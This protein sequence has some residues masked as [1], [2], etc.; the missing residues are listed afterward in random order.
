MYIS[1]KI[2]AIPIKASKIAVEQLYIIVKNPIPSDPKGELTTVGE[3]V[4]IIWENPRLA[5]IE[6][7]DQ[8]IRQSIIKILNKPNN[9]TSNP[10]SSDIT[11][12][13]SQK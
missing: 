7:K 12:T 2:T 9:Q 8:A 3:E 10:P 6:R 11:I 5:P 1:P 4:E 13:P